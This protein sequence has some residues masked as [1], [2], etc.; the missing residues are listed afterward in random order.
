LNRTSHYDLGLGGLLGDQSG[1]AID[2]P[3]MWRQFGTQSGKLVE[4]CLEVDE[5][6]DMPL[7]IESGIALRLDEIFVNCC[8]DGSVC[9][10]VIG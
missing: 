2:E 4:E 6:T 7:D 1:Q 3:L 5:S 10:A 8:L 9:R